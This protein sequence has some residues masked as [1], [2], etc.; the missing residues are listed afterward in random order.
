VLQAHLPVRKHT[1]PKTMISIGVLITIVFLSIGAMVVG[2]ISRRD[3]AR[4]VTAAEN[5]L[6]S[7]DAEITRNFELY[8]L[9]LQGV[10]DGLGFPEIASLP[11]ALRQQLLFDRAA[12]AKYLGSIFVLDRTGDLILDSRNAMPPPANHATTAT[13]RCTSARRGW[14]PTAN[15]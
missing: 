8:D 6:A 10:V 9:S 12:T 15:T 2:D 14:P 7:I 4:A 3:Y 13:A 11:P 5:V 1:Y